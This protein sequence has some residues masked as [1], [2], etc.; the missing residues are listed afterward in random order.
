M[1]RGLEPQKN[2][3]LPE[4]FSPVLVE[5]VLVYQSYRQVST[6]LLS[7]YCKMHFKPEKGD[8]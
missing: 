2:A 7:L 4:A 8:L 6:Q 1:W 5:F 3:R